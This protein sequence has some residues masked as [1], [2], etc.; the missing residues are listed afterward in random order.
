MSQFNHDLE[1]LP[2]QYRARQNKR[3]Q[4]TTPTF[5]LKETK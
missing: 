4:T 5:K 1:V 2:I 3:K